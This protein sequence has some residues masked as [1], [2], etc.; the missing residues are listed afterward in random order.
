MRQRRHWL[1]RASRS[2][3]DDDV[4]SSLAGGRSAKQLASRLRTA[5][6]EALALGVDGRHEL[7]AIDVQIDLLNRK[8]S[9]A[10]SL[11]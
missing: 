8:A 7:A 11:A 1:P 6:S 9:R 10:R 5:Q 2:G 3:V 4:R